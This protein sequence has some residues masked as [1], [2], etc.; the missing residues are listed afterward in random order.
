MNFL[1]IAG[2]LTV[3]L[4]LVA[5]ANTIRGAGRDV[6]ESAAAVEDAVN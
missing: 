2:V 6:K 4:S 3:M 5:C 1:K